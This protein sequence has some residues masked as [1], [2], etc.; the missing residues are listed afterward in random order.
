MHADADEDDDMYVNNESNAEDMD[1][2]GD[3][4]GDVDEEAKQSDSEMVDYGYE[5]EIESD[6]EEANDVN[7]EAG[8]EDD[9][10]IDE[11]ENYQ[12]YS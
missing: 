6:E 10:A 8:E 11:Y 9:I 1:G 12:L 7:Q 3:I 2:E 4:E 5:P